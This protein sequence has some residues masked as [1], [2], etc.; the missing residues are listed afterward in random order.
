LPFRFES[1]WGCIG[2]LPAYLAELGYKNP[3]DPENTLSHYATG[4]DFFGY[5][6]DDPVRL[7]RFNSAMKG[8]AGLLASPIPKPLFESIG[9]DKDAVVMVDVGGGIG[10]VTEK[11]LE[12]NP[13]IQ[14]R[15]VVQDLGKIIDEARAK[16]PKYEVME[17][18]FFTPQPVKGMFKLRL[19]VEALL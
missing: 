19:D 11:T 4:T 9:N 18:D 7:V 10:Q 3:E 2:K 16:N 5:L 12:E 13:G 1:S 15:F 8:T 17:Y 14:G 6:R